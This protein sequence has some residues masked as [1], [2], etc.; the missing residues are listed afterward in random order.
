MAVATAAVTGVATGGGGYGGSC[1]TGSAYGGGYYGG[2]GVGYLR[3]RPA[4]A[5]RRL[6]RRAPGYNPY[7]PYS[8]AQQ[9]G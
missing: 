6:R 2:G 5:G 1:G 4:S 9:Q 8:P 7:L 3:R